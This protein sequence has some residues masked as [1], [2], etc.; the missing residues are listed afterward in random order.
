KDRKELVSKL[1]HVYADPTKRS[2]LE[3][4]SEGQTGDIV[5]LVSLKDSITGD[6]LCDPHHPILLETIQFPEGV[7]SRSIEPESSADKQ[8]LTDS[9]DSLKKE[10]P[11]F[12]WRLDADTGQTLMSGMG[13]LHLEIKEHRLERDF[14]LR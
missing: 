14:R 8:N 12:T 4:I 9:L 1:Y 11:T 7:V 3:E 13:L 6:T 10:D 5:V 2:N